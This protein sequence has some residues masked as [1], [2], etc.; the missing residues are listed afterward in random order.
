MIILLLLVA[1]FLSTL[2]VL[3]SMW[4]SCAELEAQRDYLVDWKRSLKE[5]DALQRENEALRAMIKESEKRDNYLSDG[6][7]SRIGYYTPE[8]EAA[9]DA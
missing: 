4:K 9:P 3:R 5:F 2:W 6:G 7:I 8:S 1:L